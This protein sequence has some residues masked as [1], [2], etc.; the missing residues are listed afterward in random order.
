MNKLLLFKDL[1][2]NAF[3]DIKHHLITNWLKVLAWSSIA[4][5][6]VVT[7]A[8]IYRLATGFSF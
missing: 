8:F 5:I 7:Y 4:L 6:G 3:R 2:L 1:Y